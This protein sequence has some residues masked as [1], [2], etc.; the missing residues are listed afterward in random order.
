M[1]LTYNTIWWVVIT[2]GSREKSTGIIA[3]DFQSLLPLINKLL[4]EENSD[5][6]SWEIKEIKRG[7]VVRNPA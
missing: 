3:Q 5:Y 6:N 4:E 7:S 1:K 2:N